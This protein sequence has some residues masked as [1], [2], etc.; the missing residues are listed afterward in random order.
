MS[1]RKAGGF[2]WKRDVYQSQAFLS[3]GI[4]AMKFLIALYDVRIEGLD[5]YGGTRHTTTTEIAK[6]FG[7]NDAKQA[8]GNTTNKSMERYC[9]IQDEGTYDIMKK[10]DDLKQG[11]GKIVKFQ[12]K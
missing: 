9:L 6:I 11:R 12:R 4:N 10:I 2:Y 7:R 3:L 8:L 1:K 5:L